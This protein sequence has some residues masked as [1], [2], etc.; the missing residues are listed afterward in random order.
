MGRGL[1]PTGGG[2]SGGG[3]TRGGYLRRPPPEKV[4]KINC[5]QSHYG[6][7]S[8]DRATRRY[9]GVKVVVG[10]GVPG[11]VR[12]SYINL[13]ETGIELWI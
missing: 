7:V 3:H 10:A 12:G 1:P 2:G 5:G 6:P 8:G 4:R 9:K 13:V 11:P